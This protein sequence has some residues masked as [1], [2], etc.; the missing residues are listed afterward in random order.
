MNQLNV[1]HLCSTCPASELLVDIIITLLLLLSLLCPWNYLSRKLVV[2]QRWCAHHGNCI[3]AI[4]D[5][6]LKDTVTLRLTL[7]EKQNRRLE[8]CGPMSQHSDDQN[9]VQ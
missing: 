8:L 4:P 9:V 3:A 2:Q 5:L 6:A 7:W 1:L